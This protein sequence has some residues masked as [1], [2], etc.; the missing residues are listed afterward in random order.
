MTFASKF[1]FGFFIRCLTFFFMQC[2]VRIAS[3]SLLGIHFHLQAYTTLCLFLSRESIRTTIWRESFENWRI[4][5]WLAPCFGILVTVSIGLTFGPDFWPFTAFAIVIELLNEPFFVWTSWAQK[6]GIRRIAETLA[7]LIKHILIL[8]L[9]KIGSLHPFAVGQMCY[10]V[11][12]LVMYWFL[13]PFQEIKCWPAQLDKDWKKS[14]AKIWKNA[15]RINVGFL[16]SQ[17]DHYVLIFFADTSAQG[18]YMVIQNY[19]SIFV[20]LFLQPWEDTVFD[21]FARSSPHSP[22]NK[23]TVFLKFT[24]L[25]SL[26]FLCFAPF[27]AFPLVSLVLGNPW[28]E[29]APQLALY[30]FLIPFLIVNGTTEAYMR[31]TTPEDGGLWS[32]SSKI[33]LI[34]FVVH[35]VLSSVLI[36][37]FNVWGLL[38]STI[39][40]FLLRSTL[41]LF[42]VQ[43]D[44]K[45]PRMAAGT[46][47]L[48]AIVA[49]LSLLFSGTGFKDI[50]YL[51]V[52]M[53]L[54][55]MAASLL[56]CNEKVFFKQIWALGFK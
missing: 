51:L 43:G 5:S 9:L 32:L 22:S 30:C 47:I 10:A 55:V 44:A 29:L 8:F 4:L 37:M 24:V 11:T 19:G 27:C 23:I 38:F 7:V 20:R 34:L 18:K 6:D 13:C 53:V 33:Q 14:L 52:E 45:W 2:I 56:Y 40:V 3:P 1:T 17:V 12:L 46:W 21:Y 50:P 25:L 36:Q 35:A 48:F 42:Y 16:L 26:S 41:N 31:A 39:L 49:S 15:M 54:F 28:L